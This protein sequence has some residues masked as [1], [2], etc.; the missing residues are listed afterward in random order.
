MSLTATE[1]MSFAELS[2]D[3]ARQLLLRYG[4]TLECLPLH[5]TIPGSYWGE[6]E[7]G[8]I[9]TTVYVR[10]D[11]PLHSLLHE[12]CHLICM[13]QKRRAVLHTNAGGEALEENAVCYL[14]IVLADY[15]P[16][17]G[18]ERALLDMDRWG[19]S[20]RLGSAKRWFEEDAE[21]AR[22]WLCHHGLLDADNHSPIFQLRQ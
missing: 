15:L 4:L 10:P 21:D 17:F 12:S 6:T 5:T 16:D 19:Y 20:F 2:G 9:G 22:Q 18:R 14:Q 13:D 1:V 7:A 3:T 11:T 8:L